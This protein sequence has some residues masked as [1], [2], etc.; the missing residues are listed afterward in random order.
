MEDGTMVVV[1]GG[2]PMIGQTIEAEVT[3]VIQTDRGKMVFAS[4]DEA[5]ERAARRR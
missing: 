3:Q 1:E 4:V 2:A 5:P